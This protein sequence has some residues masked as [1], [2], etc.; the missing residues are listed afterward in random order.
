GAAPATPAPAAVEVAPSAAAAGHP[1]PASPSAGCGRPS[2]PA[3]ASSVRAGKLR[4]PFLLTLPEGYDGARPV[5]LVFAFHGRT[6]S[7]QLMHDTDASHLADE[8]G[9]KYAVAYVKSIGP[10]F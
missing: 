1:V 2:K 6:R 8:L 5:P 3:G 9:K 7:H 4:T 10:G